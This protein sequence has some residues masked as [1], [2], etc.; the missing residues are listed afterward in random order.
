M[1]HDDDR[2]MHDMDPPLSDRRLVVTMFV[3]VCL[4]VLLG[5]GAAL[6]LRDQI[7]ARV[8]DVASVR[9]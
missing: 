1:K 9:R 5:A 6:E 7:A 3:L 2:W 4:V 8:A